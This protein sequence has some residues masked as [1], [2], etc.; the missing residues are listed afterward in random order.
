[1][2]EYFSIEN[3]KAF[4]N[5]EQFDLKAINILTGTNSSGKSSF[6]NALKLFQ[7]NMED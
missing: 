7:F 1:M 3:F 2:L 6:T 5:E 4:E